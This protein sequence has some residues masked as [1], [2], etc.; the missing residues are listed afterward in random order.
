MRK[1]LLCHFLIFLVLGIV[2]FKCPWG[3]EIGMFLGI[4]K[5]YGAF[6]WMYK[7]AG[8]E[9]KESKDVDDITADFLGLV[10]GFILGNLIF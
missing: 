5:E 2:F 8:K 6:N 7:L 3:F 9:H 10:L 1:D 4:I